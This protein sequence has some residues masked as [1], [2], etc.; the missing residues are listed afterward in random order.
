VV[1]TNPTYHE[2]NRSRHRAVLI[3]NGVDPEVFHPRSEGEE[4]GTVEL[5]GVAP[6]P[7]QRVVVM[8]SALIASRDVAGAIRAVARVP[9]A[10]LVVAGDGPERA[11]VAALASE[12]A[13]GRHALLG[14]LER[15]RM[16]GLF[17]RADAFLHMS[18]V[19]PSA[20]VYLEAASSGLPMVVHDSPVTRWT[21]GDCATFVDTADTEAVAAGLRGV[22][23]PDAAARLGAAARRRV[24]DGWTWESL[25]ARY[26]AF[27]LEVLAARTGGA[28]P[29]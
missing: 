25:A 7:K 27:F 2:R 21:L 18:R 9:E 10:Y 11:A 8:A 17:R 3:P 15:E 16:P 13:P 19:E 4:P 24:L 5:P 23:E 22:L 26:R 28:D 1:C 20:L 6:A 29:P 14:S 12:L